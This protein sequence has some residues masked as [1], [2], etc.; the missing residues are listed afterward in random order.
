MPERR[1]Y[2]YNEEARNYDAT[3]G[4][5]ARASAAADAI[6]A[7]LP[8]GSHILDIGGGT[9]IVASF[10]VKL[11]HEV[12]VVDSSTEMVRMC[13]ARGTVPA[14]LADA[15]TL[16]M[17]SGTV[18]NAIMIWFLHI[19]DDPAPFIA[20][21]ARVLRPGGR[22]ITTVDKLR[23]NNPN[24]DRARTDAP[25]LVSRLCREAGMAERSPSSFVGLGQRDD[26]VYQLSVFDRL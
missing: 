20:E 3:R 2:D 23:S 7:L 16:P 21:V 26:P 9:G 19:I 25:E 17:P 15:K 11:G 4:G 14:I 12:T 1:D 18:D 8:T 5:D 24:H 10:L 6:H 13:E 22:F